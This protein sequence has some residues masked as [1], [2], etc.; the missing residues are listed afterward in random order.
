MLQSLGPSVDTVSPQ[1][2]ST[3]LFEGTLGAYRDYIINSVRFDGLEDPPSSWFR[4]RSWPGA[5]QD[6]PVLYRRSVK[7]RTI[8]LEPPEPRLEPCDV[9]T[10]DLRWIR[11]AVR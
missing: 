7:H 9:H 10:A 1:T 4:R 3:S 11:P 5:V 6:P 8:T 2:F